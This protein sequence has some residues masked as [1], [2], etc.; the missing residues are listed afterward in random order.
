MKK[1][2]LSL[3]L[4]TSAS[5]AASFKYQADCKTPQGQM[6]SIK[7]SYDSGYK[8]D[9]ITINGSDARRLVKGNLAFSRSNGAQVT[10]SGFPESN[11][12]TLLSVGESTFYIGLTGATTKKPYPG[13]CTV[14]DL[15][16]RPSQDLKF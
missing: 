9:E 16:A 15:N 1:I 10:L 13:V 14:K 3:L 12:E 11:Y 4:A 2:I 5:M 6:I 8:L 7:Y